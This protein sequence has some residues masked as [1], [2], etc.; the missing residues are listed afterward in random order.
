VPAGSGEGGAG[1]AGVVFRVVSYN[2]QRALHRQEL[3]CLFR[4]NA[5]LH[6][7]DVIALQ[8]ALVTESHDATEHLKSLLRGE[9]QS[10]YAPV[11]SY[12]G[13]QYGNAL[14]V[15]TP[16]R[17]VGSVSVPLPRLATLRWFE[18]LKTEGG[19]PDTKAALVALVSCPR[20]D[21]VIANVHLDF[22]GGP[23]HRAAQ[24][25]A[26]LRGMEELAA[27]I[28]SAPG[29]GRLAWV[30]LGDF[31]T[32]GHHRS[33]RARRDIER[34]LRAATEAGFLECTRE[35]SWTSDL[36]SSIDPSDPA[37]RFLQVGK[38][39]GLH[40]RQKTDHIL[41]KGAY[42]KLT[43]GLVEAPGYR[44]DLISDHVP[45]QLILEPSG[46]QR[47][48]A[49]PGGGKGAISPSVVDQPGSPMREE[50]R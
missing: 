1:E 47:G 15:K 5:D 3:G 4:E 2:I 12:P 14:L 40:F 36:L 23:L 25:E 48:R 37:R 26:V 13:K 41:L 29:R 16:C 22:S 10:V 45:I 20:Q 24:V 27:G 21:L 42:G 7:A 6:R 49:Q 11:M 39:L 18:R 38:A 35:I 44:L 46:E 33:P 9:W 43:A 50:T 34:A 8:E 17:I 30:L 28:P 19:L 32:I 31:N